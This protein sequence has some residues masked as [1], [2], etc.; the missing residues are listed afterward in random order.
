MQNSYHAEAENGILKSS[1]ASTI[2]DSE[3]AVPLHL[4]DGGL[5]KGSKTLPTDASACLHLPSPSDP[6]AHASVTAV[7]S[8]KTKASAGL[9]LGYA[10]TLLK[11]D[12]LRRGQAL[13]SKLLQSF[14]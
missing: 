14:V 3:E 7:A 6:A 5:R 13:G 8:A 9:S 2:R 1:R 11:L 10:C 12:P 4:R